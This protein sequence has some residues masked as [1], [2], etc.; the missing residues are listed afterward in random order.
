MK[1][2]NW[3]LSCACCVV[4]G[5]PL[6]VARNAAAQQDVLRPDQIQLEETAKKRQRS[7]A[8]SDE[9]QR[10]GTLSGT[11][12]SGQA[13]IAMPGPWG[14][15]DVEGNPLSITARSRA[16]RAGSGWRSS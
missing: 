2:T 10:S 5:S 14:G 4:L 7:A 13:G 16:C 6:A 15:T 11:N 9:L 1:G 12:T 8:K 3:W